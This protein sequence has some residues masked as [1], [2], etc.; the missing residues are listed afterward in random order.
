MELNKYI[1]HTVLT[2]NCSSTQISKLCE[3]AKQ[4]Q[5]KAVCVPPFYI[6]YAK[7][8]LDNSIIRLVSVVGFPMGY[9]TIASKVEEVKRAVDEGVDELDM[10]ANICAIKDN[11]WAYVQNDIDGV[12]RAAHLH[13][14][15]IK[16]IVEAHLLTNEELKKICEMCCNLG[17]NYIKTSTGFNSAATTTDQVRFIKACL[18][19]DTQI[20]A[21]GGIK[22]KEQAIQFINAGATRIGTSAG[23]QLVGVI[24]EK[25]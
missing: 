24:S 18:T 14:K 22:T 16:V 1:E 13:G 12:I 2:S 23:L 8:L 17:A 9:A 25:K 11:K 15:T 4:H 5:F 10:V 3:E 7:Q 6:K 19:N 20:K 21:S